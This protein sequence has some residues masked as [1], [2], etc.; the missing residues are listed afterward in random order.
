MQGGEQRVLRR[1]GADVEA[2]NQRLR[3][4]V[5][6]LESA[7]ESAQQAASEIK[8]AV[9]L[10]AAQERAVWEWTRTPLEETGKRLWRALCTLADAEGVST[11]DLQLVELGRL[12]GKSERAGRRA[13]DGEKGSQ[14]TGLKA[15]GLVREV[16]RFQGRV[17]IELLDPL[18]VRRARV[19]ISSLGQLEQRSFLREDE[20]RAL[21]DAQPQV[22]S[23]DRVGAGGTAGMA[24]YPPSSSPPDLSGP[25][26]AVAPYPPAVTA[27]YPPS[28]PIHS[29]RV[30]DSYPHPH[31]HTESARK[32]GWARA[33]NGGFAG[34]YGATP[35]GGSGAGGNLA[36]AV[37]SVLERQAAG[38]LDRL[39]E[40]ARLRAI[41]LASEI[42]DA[43]N[44][45]NFACLD[46]FAMALATAVEVDGDFPRHLVD[47][48]IRSVR[49]RQDGQRRI[50]NPGGWFRESVRRRA[51]KIV[52]DTLDRRGN[53]GAAIQVL[54][55]TRKPR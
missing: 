32:D 8:A 3:S 17:R 51:G 15:S 48:F 53:V 52:R 24:P 22:E 27:P 11:L 26:A 38:A 12:I 6:E 30:S 10:R 46:E 21:L 40:D 9:A 25:P 19:A 14:H 28:P 49:R 43:V 18:D 7:L 1:I 29:L 41:A 20:D 42:V 39:V 31:I 23:T 2:E 36:A 55:E 35:A 50:E 47:V 44:D 33:G 54:L 4:R 16:D 5:E 45:P 13:F 37:G 34:G